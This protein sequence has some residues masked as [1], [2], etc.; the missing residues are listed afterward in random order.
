M[1]KNETNKVTFQL[2]GRHHIEN[3]GNID[4]WEKR[5]SDVK[6]GVATPLTKYSLTKK[7]KVPNTHF[8]IVNI[9]N[10]EFEVFN[11]L[12]EARVEAERLVAKEES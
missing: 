7:T 10:V 8:N 9:E 3:F 4:L 6:A 11:T 1:A 12:D 5:I 2:S